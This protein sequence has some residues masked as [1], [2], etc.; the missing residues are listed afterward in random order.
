MKTPTE[1]T[2]LDTVLKTLGDLRDDAWLYLTATEPWRL[3]GPAAVLIS[4]EVRPELED[5]P[6]AGVPAI[7]REKN[8]MQVVPISTLKDI[9]AHARAQRANVSLSSLFD[10]LTYFYDHDAFMTL[11]SE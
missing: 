2:S 11:S 9:V 3:D 5:D 4:G 6:E 7:A 10:A 1:L 8:L